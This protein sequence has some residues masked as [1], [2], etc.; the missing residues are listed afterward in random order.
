MK[1][2]LMSEELAYKSFLAAVRH[3]ENQFKAGTLSREAT[4]K[5]ID[6]ARI[7]YRSRSL[8][9]EIEKAMR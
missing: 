7:N 8:N 1:E 2:H 6:E 4:K 3:F 9:R 5:Y